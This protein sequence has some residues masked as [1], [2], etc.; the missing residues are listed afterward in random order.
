MFKSLALAAA[1]TTLSITGLSRT[2]YA[3]ASTELYHCVFTT[4]YIGISYNTD[5]EELY[6]SG[7]MD[8]TVRPDGTLE[9][10]PRIESDV[11]LVPDQGGA[12]KFVD[13]GGNTLFKLTETNQAYD[14]ATEAVYPFEIV[15][16][17]ARDSYAGHIGACYST[18][19]PKLRDQ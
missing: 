5:A 9:D 7:P 14:G 11:K 19:K 17:T 4:P 18:S 8:Y 1:L 3:D 2:A 15:A 16:N 12:M 13:R 10:V 6:T